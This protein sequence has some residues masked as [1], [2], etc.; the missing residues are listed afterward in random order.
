MTKPKRHHV[1]RLKKSTVVRPNMFYIT[2][3]NIAILTKREQLRFAREASSEV[4]TITAT[5]IQLSL[6]YPDLV[7]VVAFRVRN[8]EPRKKFIYVQG[9]LTEYYTYTD[10]VDAPHQQLYEMTTAMIM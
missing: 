7:I 6:K 8:G 2:A 10:E 3:S 5:A 9:V 1:P 4:Y